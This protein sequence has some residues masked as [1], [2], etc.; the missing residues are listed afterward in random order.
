MR[1]KSSVYLAVAGGVVAGM[2]DIVYACAFWAIKTSVPPERIL[3][4]VA[5][6][7]LGPDSFDGG[8]AS[9]VLG[10][11]LHIAIVIVMSLAYFAAARRLP[12]LWEH[13]AVC[14]ALYGL[15]LYGVMNYVVVPLSAANPGPKDPFWIG[16]TVLAHMLLVGVPIA[17]FTRRALRSV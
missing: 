14:G 15:L 8:A 12:K 5:A 13:A 1:H 6:G 17:L 7:V 4:S 16:M 2:L 11:V 10:L 3:Q 9:A